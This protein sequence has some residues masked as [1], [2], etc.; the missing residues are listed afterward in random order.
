MA[1]CLPIPTIPKPSLP[2][3]ISLGF[4]SPSVTL[5]PALCCKLLPFPFNVTIPLPAG[6]INVAVLAS[7]A[8]Y[9]D[10]ANAWLDALQPTCPR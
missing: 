7:I 9:I 10:A 6:T 8:T 5:D 1:K 3:G 2:L 4:P